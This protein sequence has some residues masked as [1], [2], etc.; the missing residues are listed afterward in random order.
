MAERVLLVNLPLADLS[1]T[2]FFVMPPGLLSVARNTLIVKP[3]YY[4][5]WLNNP[6]QIFSIAARLA[7][8]PPEIIRRCR[9]YFRS[10]GVNN[11]RSGG[12][13]VEGVGVAE[14]INAMLL[15]SQE[16]FLR[17]FPCWHYPEAKFVT[18]RAAG[19]FLV[20]AQKKDGVCQPIT[21]LSEKGRPCSVLNPWPGRT[22]AVKDDQGNQLDVLADAKP[23]GQI[24]T[25]QTEAGKTYTVAPSEG[26][27][28][29]QPFWNAALN[30][31]AT[32][33]SNFKPEKEPGNWDVAKLT[34][35]VRIN[36][37]I[38]HRGWTSNLYDAGAHR[39]G[40]GG[41]RAG[42]ETKTIRLWPSIT[43]TPGSTPTARSP[44]SNRARLTSRTTASRWISASSSR[45][46]GLRGRRSP[47]GRSSAGRPRVPRTRI[48]SPR[49]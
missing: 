45:W 42:V 23:Y 16:G 39:M 31:P 37:R 33:S 9:G 41:S 49:M 24:C 4:V 15:Q 12:G 46:T 14:G 20:S 6:P 19:A 44:S 28:G 7:H 32:A 26:L 1:T 10:I 11:F 35:G 8:Y 48:E 22:V 18:I 30:K 47:S 13:N 43:A 25:F 38:A 29:P 2:P 36:T 21:I 34:D 3:Q 5:E 40:P 27:P 17:L